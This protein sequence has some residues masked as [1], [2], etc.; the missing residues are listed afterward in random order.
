M[1]A[2]ILAAG[3]GSRLRPMTNDKPKTLVEVNG[4]PMLKY[5]VDALVKNEVYDIVVCTGFYSRDIVNFC[6]KRYPD[7]H[8]EFVYNE[9]YET[10]NNLYTLYLAREY[11][12]GDCI[13]MNAD[14]VFDAN[15]ITKLTSFAHS[16]I[17]VDKDRF[18]EESMKVTVR[19]DGTI[20]NISKQIQ[21][22]DSYGCSID[23][24][25]FL[26]KDI[27]VVKDN[28]IEV[29]EV[30]KHKNEWTETLLDTLMN[31]KNIN[32]LPL[33]IDNACWYEIDN[34]K[35]LSVAEK[36]FNKNIIKLN[37]KKVFVL[38]LDG[39]LYLGNQLIPGS[40]EFIKQLFQ[41]KKKIY[42]MTN[43]SSRTPKYYQ[44]KL[45]DMEIE[46]EIEVISSLDLA[47]NF[48]KK[49]KLQRIYWMANV[50]VDKYMEEN[51]FIYDEN[52]PQG[53][54]LTYDTEINYKKI[55]TF[56]KLINKGVPYY[57]THT[58]MV[59]PT[60]LGYDIPDIGSYIELIKL[61][62]GYRPQKIFGKPNLYGIQHIINQENVEMKDI[63]LIGDRL[64]T[65]IKLTDNT[66]ITSILVLSGETS[67]YMYEESSI[68]ADIIVDSVKELCSYI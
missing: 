18:L 12:I 53:L 43:N 42:V 65:D 19:E 40:K 10:T 25:K 15:I 27:S 33:N 41:Q 56:I 34:Y 13:L 59:C 50:E 51:G 67:R 57:A 60:E 23:I 55:L 54:L 48:F 14:I 32:V 61:T 7:V 58:D 38:D 37:K 16:A 35:D 66:D 8:F 11:L 31:S 28:L 26:S 45:M 29:I 3:I 36:L 44:K 47:I 2:I 63:V 30:K 52:T 62:T 4:S 22:S 5:I 6:K 17:C 46:G 49:K 39:T 64:Y 21:Q 1:R 24:Y 9:E 20:K 68:K